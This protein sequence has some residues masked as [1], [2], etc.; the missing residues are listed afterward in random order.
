MRTCPNC[1]KIIIGRADKVFCDEYCKSAFQYKK[2][3]DKA[4]SFFSIVDKQL[5]LNRKILKQFNKGG[6]STVR[7][8]DLISAGFNP[9]HFTH[10]WKNGKGDVYLFCYEF[11]FLSMKDNG[12]DK[13]VLIQWQPY[14][15]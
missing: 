8:D 6:K 3:K 4:Q 5:K 1:Q 13:Y 12:K 7:K 2:N 9:K 15:N 11:G 14:M 10:Y